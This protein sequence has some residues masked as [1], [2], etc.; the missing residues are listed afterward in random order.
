M[1]EAGTRGPGMFRSWLPQY[2]EVPP[3]IE[4]K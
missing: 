1:K 2:I 3:N 4:V